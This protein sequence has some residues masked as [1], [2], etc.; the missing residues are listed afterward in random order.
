VLERLGDG[1]DTGQSAYGI[2]LAG[3]GDKLLVAF[4]DS[5][6]NLNVTRFSVASDGTIKR[7]GTTPTNE[8]V[9]STAM[10]FGYLP[11]SNTMYWANVVNNGDNNSRLIVWKLSGGGPVRMDSQEIGYLSNCDVVTLPST[12]TQALFAV[13]CI[14]PIPQTPGQGVAVIQFYGLVGGTIKNALSAVML[15]WAVPSSSVKVAY[16]GMGSTGLP[17]VLGAYRTS[18][19]ELSLQLVRGKDYASQLD[20]PDSTGVLGAADQIAIA[21]D[22]SARKAEVAVRKPS[23]KIEMTE[24]SVSSTDKLGAGDVVSNGSGSDPAVGYLYGSYWGT[25]DRNDDGNLD[26]DVLLPGLHEAD[27]GGGTTQCAP[28]LETGYSGIDGRMYTA[29]ATS[30]GNLKL[31]A[32][33]AGGFSLYY[34][35]SP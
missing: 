24:W 4:G 35:Y 6:G 19:G 10:D 3:V 32:W 13:G 7:Y 29:V 34:P 31:I 20:S 21:A 2:S 12:A 22:P 16:V 15:G 5:A 28:A 1:Y 26:V 14:S 17:V 23:G 9:T 25:A 11:G 30:A 18:A 33:R 8:D 27:D